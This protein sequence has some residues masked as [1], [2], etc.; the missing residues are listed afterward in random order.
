MA[1]SGFTPTAAMYKVLLKAH[2]ALGDTAAVESLLSS[3]RAAG[4]EVPPETLAALAKGY[5]HGGHWEAAEEALEAVLNSDT[6]TDMRVITVTAFVHACSRAGDLPHIVRWLQRLPSLGLVPT[7]RMWEIAVSTAHEAGDAAAADA[8]WREAGGAT[9]FGLY[10]VLVPPEEGASSGWTMLV[11]HPA[12]QEHAPGAALDLSTC[13]AG[14]IHTALRAEV[15]WLRM[16]P[17]PSVLYV[18]YIQ[19]SAPDEHAIAAS[20]AAAVMEAVGLH[21]S[22]VPGTPGLFKA[23]LPSH[24][25]MQQ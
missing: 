9:Y 13:T 2:A 6:T 18:Y 4:E 25:S 22:A 3:M 7:P 11:D 24:S 20:E 17:V 16:Q 8:L 19:T 1:E 10:K 14:V 5:G 21:I 23:S 12:Q 15:S